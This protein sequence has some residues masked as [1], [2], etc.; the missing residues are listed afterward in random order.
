MDNRETWKALQAKL[1]LARERLEVRDYAAALEAVDAALGIDPEFLAAHSLRQRIELDRLTTAPQDPGEQAPGPPQEAA[2][3]S[4]DTAPPPAPDAA[5]PL[6]DTAAPPPANHRR[7]GAILADVYKH[8]RDDFVRGEESSRSAALTQAES[9]PPDETE[10]PIPY[11]TEPLTPYASEPPKPYEPARPISFELK[12]PVAYEEPPVAYENELP[13][14]EDEFR[15]TRNVG[16]TG[17]IELR[18][19][20]DEDADDFLHASDRDSPTSRSTGIIQ[21]IV[22]AAVLIAVILVERPDRYESAIRDLLRWPEQA[23]PAPAPLMSSPLPVRLTKLVAGGRSANFGRSAGV[24]LSGRETVAAP[25]MRTVSNE[26]AAPVPQTAAS[27]AA[28][29]PADAAVAA[30]DPNRS[31]ARGRAPVTP[32]S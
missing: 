3:I 14:P 22:G 25:T 21:V 9:P 24:T 2:S 26:T 18:L 4:I 7:F 10:Q 20:N 30:V 23:G 28:P 5:P 8:R 32:G 1:A 17:F 16:D 29:F 12:R 6:P 11:A 31:D 13:I 27:A 19:K 15:T